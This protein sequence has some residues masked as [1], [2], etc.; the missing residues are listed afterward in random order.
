MLIMVCVVVSISEILV[1]NSS[2]ACLSNCAELTSYF[3]LEIYKED[4]HDN[5]VDGTNGLLANAWYDLLNQYWNSSNKSGNPKNIRKIVG[6]KYKKYMEC[7][8]Q[9]TNE[10][11][12]IF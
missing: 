4:I 6:S 5:N 10:F 7:N 1:M 9:D 8:Q 12:T 11:M 2:I 3:L